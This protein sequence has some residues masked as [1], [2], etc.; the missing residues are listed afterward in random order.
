MQN[1]VWK[2]KRSIV[3][4][5]QTSD[6]QRRRRNLSAILRR[7]GPLCTFLRTV[8]LALWRQLLTS[9][10]KNIDYIRDEREADT[11]PTA[12]RQRDE[13]VLSM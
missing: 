4:S 7:G 8:W 10:R 3:P 1:A 12:C 2:R 13:R 9:T 5:V 11:L 6:T